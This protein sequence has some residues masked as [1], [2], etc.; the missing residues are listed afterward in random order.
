MFRAC[1]SLHHLLWSSMITRPGSTSTMAPDFSPKREI[2]SSLRNC[3]S[4]EVL[5]TAP[6]SFFYPSLLSFLFCSLIKGEKL[7]KEVPID[8]N[9]FWLHHTKQMFVHMKIIMKHAP[10]YNR[11]D[12][13]ALVLL[14]IVSSKIDSLHAWT[15][16]FWMFFDCILQ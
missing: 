15:N 10:I 11:H 12:V 4:E 5:S 13:F 6:W 2:M 8:C 3:Y 16:W 7:V 14:Y 9:S 1:A